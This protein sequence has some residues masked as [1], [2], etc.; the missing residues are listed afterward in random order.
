MP[1]YVG[2][3]PGLQGE[4][5]ETLGQLLFDIVRQE[6]NIKFHRFH[7]EFK[8]T[9]LGGFSNTLVFHIYYDS[10]DYIAIQMRNIH[11]SEGLYYEIPYNDPDLI[12]K[13]IQHLQDFVQKVNRVRAISSLETEA[14]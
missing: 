1:T 6:Q 9:A 12:A 13:A 14:P 4:I 10:P 2:Q 3:L 7:P 11:E 8:I 5:A